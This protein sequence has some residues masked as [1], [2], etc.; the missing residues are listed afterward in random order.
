MP[1]KLSRPVEKLQCLRSRR[2]CEERQGL[3]HDRAHRDPLGVL[4]R[5][6]APSDDN[7]L[8]KETSTIADFFRKNSP[9]NSG[10]V[11][12][13]SFVIWCPSG[14]ETLRS[15]GLSTAGR[16]PDALEG[17]THQPAH[18]NSESPF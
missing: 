9:C 1:A 4:R 18:S 6:V 15:R 8:R 7:F 16:R 13:L 2:N 14:R 10:V 5:V 12:R 11:H 17:H 3:V